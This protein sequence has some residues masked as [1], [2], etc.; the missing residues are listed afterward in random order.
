MCVL[1]IEEQREEEILFSTT[2]KSCH[3]GLPSISIWSRSDRWE[4]AVITCDQI[5]AWSLSLHCS[6]QVSV[7]CGTN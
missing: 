5:Q 2:N 6:A 3:I 4:Y 1:M 7:I